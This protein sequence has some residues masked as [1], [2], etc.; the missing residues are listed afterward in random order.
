M[1]LFREVGSTLDLLLSF[2]NRD[3]VWFHLQTWKSEV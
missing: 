3:V 2:K 1:V